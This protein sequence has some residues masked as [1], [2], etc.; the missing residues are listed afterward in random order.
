MKYYTNIYKTAFSISQLTKNTDALQ[1]YC[2]R[3]YIELVS[4]KFN[5][6]RGLDLSQS[7]ILDYTFSHSIESS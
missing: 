7:P 3:K 1:A 4:Y 6:R 5:Y 2:I